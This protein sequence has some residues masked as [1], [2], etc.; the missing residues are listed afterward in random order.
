M[1]K[2]MSMIS[3]LLIITVLVIVA[4]KMSGNGELVEKTSSTLVDKLGLINVNQSKDSFAKEALGWDIRDIKKKRVS[5]VREGK[6]RLQKMIDKLESVKIKNSVTSEGAKATKLESAEKQKFLLDS[7]NE[8]RSY[9][10]NSAAVYPAIVKGR[11]YGS[12]RQL[13][14][15]TADAI[16]K[17]NTLK[18][19][20][21]LRTN[22]TEYGEYVTVNI[23]K[24]LDMAYQIMELLDARLTLAEM[25]ENQDEFEGVSKELDA[26]SARANVIVSDGENTVLQLP[27]G[28]TDGQSRDASTIESFTP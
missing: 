22:N 12:R 1:V 6:R 27:Q 23:E 15:A 13:E 28:F 17:Y 14:A 10:Q 18:R 26:L 24:Q 9:L 8:A 5:T 11:S 3:F 21:T 4:L 7:I 19:A 25:Q 20:S 2:L 16:R